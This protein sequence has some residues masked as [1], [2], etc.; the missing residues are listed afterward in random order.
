MLSTR[1]AA[2][3]LGVSQASVRRWSDSGQL[4]VR[5]L[6]RR[7]DRRFLR[8]DVD[9][10]RA[11]G[12]AQGEAPPTAQPTSLRLGGATVPFNTHLAPFYDSDEGRMRLALPF[13]A[14]GLRA[15]E[16]CFLIA[17][18]AVLDD[19][20]DRLGRQPD[21]DL[22]G[23]VASGQLVTRPGPGRT[24]KEALA[25]WEDSL[26]E[27]YAESRGPF[28]AVAEMARVRLQFESESAMLEFEAAV[29]AVLKRFPVVVL[30]QYDVREFSGE[31]VLTALKTHPDVF[32]VPLGSLLL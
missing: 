14:D 32:N 6:G 28:R 29:T 12:L 22:E 27:R 1:E 7:K 16:T 30:C 9:R 11:A 24:V 3:I 23:K 4:R 5:R 19:Y 21:L 2:D 31:A 25:F 26:W 13:L 8:D 10:F 15:G 17:S 18:G 20:L